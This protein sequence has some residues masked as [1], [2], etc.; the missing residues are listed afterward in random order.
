V[1]SPQPNPFV[2]VSKELLD[3]VL[4]AR[5][6]ATHQAVFLAIVRLSYGRRDGD[7]NAKTA[8]VSTR[9]LARITGRDRKG[10]QRSLDDLLANNVIVESPV[11]GPAAHRRLVGPQKDYERWGRF[12]VRPDDVPVE[13]RHDWQRGDDGPRGAAS[14]TQEVGPGSSVPASGEQSPRREG[15]TLPKEG[16]DGRPFKDE[17]VETGD[18]PSFSEEKDAVVTAPAF[19]KSD[20]EVCPVRDA[21]PKAAGVSHVARAA[22]GTRDAG[23]IYNP[24]GDSHRVY[25]RVCERICAEAHL[26]AAASCEARMPV[27]QAALRRYFEGLGN[28]RPQNWRAYTTRILD[29]ADPAD[30]VGEEI[31]EDWRALEKDGAGTDSAIVR[32]LA[33]DLSGT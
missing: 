16:D 9:L 24:K 23:A 7:R 31:L 17:T 1:A 26:S 13:L 32:C 3:A 6:P 20:P 21:D 15:T 22:L 27:C 12:S 2:Q 5:M 8:W 11:A 29:G 10:V 14:P 18:H 28:A 30:L 4:R 19:S 33:R 25:S